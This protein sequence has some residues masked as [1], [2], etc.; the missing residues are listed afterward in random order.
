MTDNQQDA[1]IDQWLEQGLQQWEKYQQELIDEEDY[2]EWLFFKTG[3]YSTKGK[4]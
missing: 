3:P 1:K 4:Q 2:E